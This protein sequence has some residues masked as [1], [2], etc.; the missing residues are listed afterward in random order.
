[1]VM[2][3]K[4]D[5]PGQYTQ[6][7]FWWRFSLLSI[8]NTVSLPTHPRLLAD[9]GTASP[10]LSN[11]V[12]LGHCGQDP[13]NSAVFP[14]TQRPHASERCHMPFPDNKRKRSL[15]NELSAAPKKSRTKTPSA[16]VQLI[17]VLSS[18]I[19]CRSLLTCCLFTDCNRRHRPTAAA[20]VQSNRES[21]RTRRI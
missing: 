14:R 2:L 10:V 15:W 6:T 19:H 8:I 21:I 7:R 3:K 1:M 12:D 9:K 20:S 18:S 16:F 5:P 11:D 17:Q 4:A 13:L